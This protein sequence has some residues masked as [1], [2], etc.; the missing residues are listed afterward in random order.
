MKRLS[1]AIRPRNLL[2]AFLGCLFGTMS[3]LGGENDME[4]AVVIQYLGPQNK[5]VALL[6]FAEGVGQVTVATISEL[7]MGDGAMET[8]IQEIAVTPQIMI[9]IL[10]AVPA[11]KAPK[12]PLLRVGFVDRPNGKIGTVDVEE[13]GAID[14][15]N[16]VGQ[17]ISAEPDATIVFKTWLGRT[18]LVR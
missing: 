7:K 1:A 2:L 12:Q 8:L 15:A 11:A 17:A 10:D 9:R 4:R 13:A 3:V 16:A 18:S 14:F 6:A 5:T